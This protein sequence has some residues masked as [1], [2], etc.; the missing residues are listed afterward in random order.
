MLLMHFL[1]IYATLQQQQLPFLQ[2]RER[3]QAIITTL[4][5]STFSAEHCIL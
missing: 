2:V 5:A 1:T 4:T 3:D